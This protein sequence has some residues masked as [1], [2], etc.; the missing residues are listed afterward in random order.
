MR[1]I[2]RQLCISIFLLA[3]SADG[4]SGEFQE[5]NDAYAQ[6]NFTSAV[7]KYTIAAEAGDKS[8]QYA[9]ASMYHDGEGVTR[10]HERAAY[11]YTQAAQRGH[12][13]AQYWLCIMHREAIGVP[14]DYAEAF[15]WCRRA[16]E[17][18]HAQAL[19]AVGQ[20]YFDGLGNGF[21]RDH[22]RAYVWFSRAAAQGDGDALLM[23]EKLEHDMTPLQ[24]TEA[25]RQASKWA[26]GGHSPCSP[27]NP[28]ARFC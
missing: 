8:A 25:R 24:V 10:D 26:P 20:F 9:L 22:V 6:G 11:W 4:Y 18:G 21:T 3:F 28:R 16:S 14:R 5:A 15:Y 17:K 12:T 7:V 19:F 13:E 1:V 23:I 2:V 27:N